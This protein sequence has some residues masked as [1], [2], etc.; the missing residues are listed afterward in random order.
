MTTE[1]SDRETA[2]LWQDRYQKLV[3]ILRLFM[4]MVDSLVAV[5]LIVFAD[6]NR[7]TSATFSTNRP[8]WVNHFPLR[9]TSFDRTGIAS[10]TR[11]PV[12]AGR[13]WYLK[14]NVNEAL[15]IN[16]VNLKYAA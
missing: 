4:A 9:I 10:G 15:L 13:Q 14:L 12:L 5:Y 2:S 6:S 11:L 16:K 1:L 8:C 3:R 7:N